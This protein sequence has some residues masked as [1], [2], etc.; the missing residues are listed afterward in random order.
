M[1]NFNNK[2]L[3]LINLAIK[4]VSPDKAYD[5]FCNELEKAI[6]LTF[7]LLQI[8]RTKTYLGFSPRDFF[9]FK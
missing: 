9:S 7:A 6:K 1:L 3:K 2:L 8:F 5:H 4:T